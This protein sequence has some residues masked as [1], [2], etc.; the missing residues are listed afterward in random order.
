[1]DELVVTR[2]DVDDILID[3]SADVGAKKIH[4]D[5]TVK[6]L[7]SAVDEAISQ[8]PIIIDAYK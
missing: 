5:D 6:T 3:I 1:L 8:V 4:L 2:Q 7:T